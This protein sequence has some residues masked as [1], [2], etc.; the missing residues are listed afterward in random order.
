MQEFSPTRRRIGIMG[1]SFDPVHSGHLVVAS[2][3][4][5]ALRLDRVWFLPAALPPHKLD[6]NRAPAEDR[7]EMLRL[8]TA[9]DPRFEV[10]DVELR[11]GGVSYTVDT[12]ESLR[13][14][15]PD[16]DWTLIL[17]SDGLV[18]LHTWRE[19]DR[20]LGLCEPAVFVRPGTDRRSRIEAALR[21]NGM[22]ADRLMK[23]LFDAHRFEVSSTE[24]RERI[25]SGRSVRYLLPDAVERYVRR[26]GLYGS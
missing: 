5:E 8:A 3:A 25:A 26:R 23:R 14:E 24:V 4:I 1:G 7:L 15:W 22:P 21:A 11:R 18:E 17:G 2:D 19:V 9:D 20:L 13:S 16:V 10:S 6:R 12:L